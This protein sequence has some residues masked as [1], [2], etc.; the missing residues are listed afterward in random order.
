MAVEKYYSQLT[1]ACQNKQPNKPQGQTQ[2]EQFTSFPSFGF[3]CPRLSSPNG[4]FLELCFTRL[5]LE[6][7]NYLTFKI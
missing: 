2:Y 5:M 1:F 7:Q 4:L 3:I 6:R